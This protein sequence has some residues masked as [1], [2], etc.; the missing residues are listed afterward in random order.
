MWII[1]LL[2]SPVAFRIVYLESREYLHYR[3]TATT[4][5]Q[6][7]AVRWY[8][9]KFVAAA[10]MLVDLPAY[11]LLKTSSA[12]G[13]EVKATG[14]LLVFLFLLMVHAKFMATKLWR[15]EKE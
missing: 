7:T 11:L 12:P 3:R 5:R 2:L 10:V 4:L 14:W 8:S 1:T 13:W 15:D 9:M 6:L